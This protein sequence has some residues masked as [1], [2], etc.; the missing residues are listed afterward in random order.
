MKISEIISSWYK[1]NKRNLPWRETKDPYKIWLSEVILQQTRV[2]QGIAYYER[3]IERFPDLMTLAEANEQ[4]VLK[5]W[6]GLG[7]YSRARNL[8]SAAKQVKEDYGSQFPKEAQSLLKLKGV[9]P[10]TAAA[11]ASFS[12]GEAVAV[13]DGNVSRVLS[14]LFAVTEPVNTSGGF[15]IITELANEILDGDKPGE[16]NQA[17]MEFGAM[18]CIPVKPDCSICPLQVKCAA[19]QQKKVFTYPVKLK[20]NRPTER[21][22]TYLIIDQ[23]NYT[24]IYKRKSRDI[25][26]ELYEFPLIETDCEIQKDNLYNLITKFLGLKKKD[27]SIKL[28]SNTVKHFLSHRI[29]YAKFVHIKVVDKSY[30]GLANWE[31]V[32]V[33]DIAKHPLPRLVDRYLE[34][35][36]IT[37][38]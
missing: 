31:K 30:Q 29:I 28:V 1:K 8:L 36:A 10:Y 20:P 2:N 37:S 6:Q 22:F 15:K 23:H 11:I 21:F 34:E 3:F 16:H 35:T 17:L 9:G 12:F 4:E 33:N 25:W 24:Y 18:Q 13:V 26:K 27:F 32:P 14:R 19:F 5:L 38:F 7:Y